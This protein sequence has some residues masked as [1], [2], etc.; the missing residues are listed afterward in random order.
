MIQYRPQRGGL[1]ASM[2]EMKT[3]FDWKEFLVHIAKE[4]DQA[5]PGN[6]IGDVF[7]DV[8]VKKY[9]TGIDERI[10]WDTHIVTVKGYVIGF[11]DG[12]L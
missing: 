9:G 5:F 1:A 8:E 3:F 11:T 10:G 12:P 4:W 7:D 2:R 6:K